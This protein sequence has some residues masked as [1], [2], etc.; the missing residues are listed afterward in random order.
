MLKTQ[1]Y[2]VGYLDLLGTKDKIDNG[3]NNYL[4][5]IHDCF[6]LAKIM[7][8]YHSNC[9]NLFLK[10]KIFSDNIII[11]Q[12]IKDS[13][14]NNSPVIAFNRICAL[15][16]SV[17]RVFL[18]NDIFL[19][20]GI[21]CDEL[22]IDDVLVWGKALTDAYYIENNIAIYPRIVISKD[23]IELDPI[24]NI[25]NKMRSA[26]NII[27]DFDGEFFIDY[28]NYPDDNEIQKL[29][30]ISN[31]NIEKHL[32]E[33]TDARILQKIYWQKNYIQKSQDRIET[34]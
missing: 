30:Q 5:R 12:P 8:D 18:C 28:L 25:G 20:G 23:L 26:N 22:Y 3:Q 6:M 15:V 24:V 17:Q 32:A 1:K 29:I 34:K 7:V 14:S 4:N 27:Q 16:S 21:V 11:A 9:E 13:M 33:E 19:R 2:M 10:Y 31:S